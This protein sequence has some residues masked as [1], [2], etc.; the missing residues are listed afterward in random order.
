PLP[1][2]TSSDL[3]ARARCAQ[4]LEHADRHRDDNPA[5][6]PLALVANLVVRVW[7]REVERVIE[8]AERLL[9]GSESMQMPLF[10]AWGRIYGGWALA[11]RGRGADSIPGLREGLMEHANSGQLL[12]LPQYLGPLAEA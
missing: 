12:G 6:Q 10:T 9:G 2:R 1:P 5:F 11:M 7:L 4:P 3:H 8:L